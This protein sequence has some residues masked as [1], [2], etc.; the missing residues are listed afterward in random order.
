[1]VIALNTGAFSSS[2]RKLK[3][4]EVPVCTPGSKE[5][6][7][8]PSDRILVGRIPLLLPDE[9]PIFKPY[10]VEK[11]PFNALKQLPRSEYILLMH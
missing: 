8:S 7:E 10:W 9:S 6:R 5:V 2:S 4:L 1:M 11:L 3:L